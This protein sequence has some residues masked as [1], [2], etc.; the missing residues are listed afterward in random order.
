[1]NTEMLRNFATDALRY[2]EPR[3]IAY[4]ALLAGVVLWYFAKDWPES[5]RGIRFDGVLVLF[6]L[7]VLANVAYCAAYVVDLFLQFSHFRE[8]RGRWRV[9]I[10]VIGFAFAAALTRF[11]AVGM[12]HPRISFEP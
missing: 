6:I 1:M 3:R 2:W 4:N 7:A 12:F 8:E 9:L 5:L 11:F 10:V